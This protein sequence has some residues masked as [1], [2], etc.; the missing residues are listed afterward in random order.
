MTRKLLEIAA[1]IVRAQ[2]SIGEMSPDQIELSLVK[3]FSTLQKMQRAEEEG[4]IIDT[5]KTSEEASEDK[6]DL[7]KMDA[8]DSIQD[9]RIICMECGA[10]MRQLTAKHLGSHDLNPREYK[11][12]WGF[13]LKQSLSA[14]A[15]SKARSKAAKKRGLPANLLKF[16]QERKEKK[17]ETSLMDTPPPQ[18]AK[19]RAQSDRPKKG[20]AEKAGTE[21]HG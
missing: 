7:Q 4:A 11:K 15:L 18:K 10:E 1:D 3:T 14:K 9:E 20:R 5:S 12:K 8:R 19:P 16:Q 2:A 21:E 6:K 13:P 17:A